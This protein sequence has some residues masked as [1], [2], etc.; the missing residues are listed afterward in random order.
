M[1]FE[2]RQAELRA[3]R[4]MVLDLLEPGLLVHKM[5]ITILP[6]LIISTIGYNLVF[7]KPESV[8][9]NS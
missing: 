2:A 3:T 5:G 1:H 6:P 9:L 8:E 7:L 4:E